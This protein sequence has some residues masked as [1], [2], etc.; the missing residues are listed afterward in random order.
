MPDKQTTGYIKLLRSI[1]GRTAPKEID[2]S[3]VSVIKQVLA[4]L[5]PKEE[6]LLRL[7][8][9]LDDG[10]A[11]TVAS[12][13]DDFELTRERVRQIQDKALRKL[14]HPSRSGRLLVSARVLA[15]REKRA[16]RTD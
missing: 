13:G 4:T 9:G 5:T 8:F 14:R 1:F 12:V 7:R 2:S 15:S 16:A 3:S 10:R 6:R 11:R